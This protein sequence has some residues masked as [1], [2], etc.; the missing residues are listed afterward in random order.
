MPRTL[1]QARAEKIKA[2]GGDVKAARAVLD[3]QEAVA[4]STVDESAR[5]A[6][7][8]AFIQL[9]KHKPKG[10]KHEHE[11]E[12]G[13][14]ATDSPAPS[15]DDPLAPPPDVSVPSTTSLMASPSLA[16]PSAS[17]S[18]SIRS[19]ASRRALCHFLATSYSE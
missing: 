8:R 9:A 4:T 14:P 10:H 7:S 18:S 5:A 17:D 15:P 19:G 3:G 11:H 6:A 1:L 13:S 12:T 2:H 16:S